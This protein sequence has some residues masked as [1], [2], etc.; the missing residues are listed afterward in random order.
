MCLQSLENQENIAVLSTTSKHCTPLADSA[1]RLSQSDCSIFISILFLKCLPRM[2]PVTNFPALYNGC[3]LS[4]GWHRVAD[5]P[6]LDHVCIYSLASWLQVASSSHWFTALSIWCDRQIWFLWFCFWF[7]ESQL[8]TAPIQR[9]RYL[10]LLY[11]LRLF[12]WRTI[13]LITP[14]FLVTWHATSKRSRNRTMPMARTV[15]DIPSMS[16]DA[17][18]R[19]CQTRVVRNHKTTSTFEVVIWEKIA[20]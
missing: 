1:R 9:L 12:L 10:H 7:Y 4:R 2:S 3:M 11:V 13:L 17:I 16:E 15:S 5:F 14:L 20:S 6:A 18:S 8:K 19:I